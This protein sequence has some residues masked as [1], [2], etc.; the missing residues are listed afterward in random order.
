[1][2]S[3][4]VILLLAM[5]SPLVSADMYS[6]YG[7]VKYPNNTAVQYED[8]SIQCEPHA[9]DCTKFSGEAVMT[10]FGGIYRLDLPFEAG[11]EGVILIIVVK[12]EQFH[13]QISTQNATEDG[14]D[15]RAEFNLTLEQEPP[16]SALSA[17]F[18]CGTIFFILVFANVLVRTGKQLMTPEGRQRFQ[19]RSPMPVTKC[20]ICGGIVRRHLLVR[21]LIVEHDI[22]PD[23]AGALAGLQFSDE[24]HDL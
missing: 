6:I 11:D 13:H 21:H 3:V 17:G 7:V 9:Y 4:I 20:Q 14:G 19:G 5:A 10:N 22:P 24:R 12:G 23:D 16:L 8:V 1:M 18:V 2:R 15:Y